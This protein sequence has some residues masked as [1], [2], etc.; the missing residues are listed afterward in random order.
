MEPNIT[1]VAI[2]ITLSDGTRRLLYIED[3]DTVV[4][5][6]WDRKTGRKI[7]ISGFREYAVYDEPEMIKSI[8]A[9]P[10]ESA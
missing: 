1:K 2:L 7:S 3:P 8:T 6:E 10:N 9:S 5:E 4:A